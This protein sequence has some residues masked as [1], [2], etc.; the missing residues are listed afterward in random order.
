MY[1][2]VFK[3]GNAVAADAITI[4]SYQRNATTGKAE[5]KHVTTLTYA[6]NYQ[7]NILIDSCEF[8]NAV[9]DAIHFEDKT[10]VVLAMQIDGISISTAFI[11][12]P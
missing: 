2:Y 7:K 6:D 9:E 3:Y 5:V 10:E 8:K 1:G 11:N 4:T 12:N